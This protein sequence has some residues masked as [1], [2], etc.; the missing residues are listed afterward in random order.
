DHYFCF[1]LDFDIDGTANSFLKEELK[2]ERLPADNPRRSVW[3][4][5]P[6]IA[7]VEQEA[8]LHMMMEPPALW[9]VINPNVKGPL[10][11]PV[12]YEIAAGDNAVSLRVDDDG[13][14]KRAASIRHNLWVTPYREDERYPAGDYPTQSH[15]G[16]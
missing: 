5:E 13:P 6:R 11:Y 8:Q 4:A 2:T 3:V 14:Q 10:G 7:K 15:G 1:R 12:S 16:D 9:R